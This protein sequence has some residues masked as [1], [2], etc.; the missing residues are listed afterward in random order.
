MVC[1]KIIPSA[2]RNVDKDGSRSGRKPISSTIDYQDEEAV[3]LND[4][5]N[6]S[7]WAEYIFFT[8][9][10]INLMIIFMYF[11]HFQFL[12]AAPSTG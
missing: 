4:S 3:T 9:V 6:P 2:I 7:A 10:T 11:Y 5:L 1:A 12:E 8:S